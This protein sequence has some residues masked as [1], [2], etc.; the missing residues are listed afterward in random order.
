MVA[1]GLVG[2]VVALAVG[3]QALHPFTLRSPAFVD[4]GTLPASSEYRGGFGCHG[5]NRAPLLTWSGVPAGTRSFALAVLDPDAAPFIPGGWVHWVVYNIPADAHALSAATLAR[6]TQGTTS[7]GT[8]GY[9]GPCPPANGEPHHY[10]FTL[11]ALGVARLSGHAL[12][13][14]A[15]LRAMAGHILGAT[16][17]V[18]TFRR[19]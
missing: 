19:P 5:L 4:G 15:L 6:S 9:G 2:V 17:I 11:Y 10:V 8:R 3:V 7:F 13:R 12:T 16:S 18:G 14:D 1:K